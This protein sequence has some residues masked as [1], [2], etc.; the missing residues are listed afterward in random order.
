MKRNLQNYLNQ[1][2][3][4]EK[5]SSFD[6]TDMDMS[7]G[8]DMSASGCTHPVRPAKPYSILFN[9]S[10]GG[11][12]AIFTLFGFNRY[13]DIAKWGSDAGIV[14]TVGGNITYAELLA[15]SQRPFLVRRWRFISTNALN[16]NQTLNVNYRDANGRQ[17]IDTMDMTESQD[18]YATNAQVV[19]T[20]FDATIDGSFYINGVLDASSSLKVIVYP[21]AIVNSKNELIGL[22]TQMTYLQPVL[23]PAIAP[24]RPQLTATVASKALTLK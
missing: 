17:I 7:F 19:D 15:Q 1:L 3:N 23:S 22:P 8:G 10:T 5:H 16:L 21:E 20:T 6:G 12:G 14:I 18:M 9:N 24:A 13:S 4:T 2:A 11:A